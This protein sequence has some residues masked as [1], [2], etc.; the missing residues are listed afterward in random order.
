MTILSS[1]DLVRDAGALS[2]G[3][4]SEREGIAL[5]EPLVRNQ[6]LTPDAATTAINVV[7]QYPE[8]NL[9]EVPDAVAHARSL[10]D[11]IEAN[12]P[13]I[14]VVLTGVSMLNNAFSETGVK[15]PEHP[16]A[17]D[18]RPYSAPDPAHP[19][20]CQR[21]LRDTAGDHVLNDGGHGLGRFCRHQPDA[22]IRLR[23]DHHPDPGDR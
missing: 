19:S 1:R 13:D 21:N 9:T 7:L 2:A 12:Y 8:L 15:D 11:Q 5:A 16:G 14:D 17:D 6:L 3:E 20:F 22:D 10:R 4:R 23:A 18:V